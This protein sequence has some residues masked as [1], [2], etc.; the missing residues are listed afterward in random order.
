ML[1][2]YAIRKDENPIVLVFNLNIL[3]HC[4]VRLLSSFGTDL[5]R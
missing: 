5:G 1:N 3:E 4:C 2:N